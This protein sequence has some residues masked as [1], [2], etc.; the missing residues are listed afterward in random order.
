MARCKELREIKNNNTWVLW[1]WN[2]YK[3]LKGIINYKRKSDEEMVKDIYFKKMN[4]KL[5]LNNPIKYN[6]KVQWLKLYYKN[7]VMTTC[8]DKYLVRSHLKNKG[9]GDL[10]NNLIKVYESVDEIRLNELPNKFVLKGTHGSGWNIIVNDKNNFNWIAWKLVMK[11]WLNQNFY[12]YGRE[13]P[14][15]DIKPRIICEEFLEDSQGEGI[16]DY[17]V[18]CFNGEPK[19]VQV[20]V[21]RFTSHKKN[22]YDLDW[23]LM[24]LKINEENINVG[25]DKPK[26]FNLMIKIARELSNDFPHV[27]VD[28]YEVKEQLVFG[29]LTF[30]PNNGTGR[31][32]PEEYEIVLG[33]WLK[34]PSIKLVK[35]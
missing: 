13:W 14:Y 31:I 2:E 1:I 19:F 22:F 17:K 29:E 28:F 25:I 6:E 21:S 33:K 16:N 24:P 8:A 32:F 10:L 35:T 11:S 23:N 5:N 18:F 26:N 34:L 7:P 4:E 9:F 27:R 15:K 12:Y 20:D 3:R 30:F